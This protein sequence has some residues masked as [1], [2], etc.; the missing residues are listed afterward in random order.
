[1]KNTP[2]YIILL[3]MCTINN[4]HMIHGS[5]DMK[6]DREFFDTFDCFLPFY[7]PKNPKNQN[8]E[9]LKKCLEILSFYTCAPKMTIIWCMVPEIWSVTG[10]FFCHFGLLF[11]ILPPNNPKN[12]NFEKLKKMPGGII[13]L[14]MCT[15]NDNQMMYGSWDIK[16]D[17][18][19]FLSFWTI[20]CPFTPLT[21][22]KIKISKKWKKCLEMSSFYTSV[23]KI[24]SYGILFLRYCTWDM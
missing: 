10:K 4:N 16:H 2:G 20:F 7:P 12:Q 3:H 17:R 13:I 8:F 1:M 6:R 18:Q 21:A 9:K 23:T 24:W 19:T 14:Y 5:W 22:R 15:I 11:A